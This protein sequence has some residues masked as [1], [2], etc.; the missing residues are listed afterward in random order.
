MLKPF[1]LF[2]AFLLFLSSAFALEVELGVRDF[3]T[4]E[5]MFFDYTLSEN[6][7]GYVTY[8]ASIF[9]PNGS[10]NLLEEETVFLNGSYS[11]VYYGVLVDEYFGP[12][13]CVASLWVPG[14]NVSVEKEFKVIAP[15]V[16]QCEVFACSDPTCREVGSFVVGDV[17]Y[18]GFSCDVDEVGTE[19]VLSGP[20]DVSE[21]SLPASVSLEKEGLYV[22]NATFYKDGYIPAKRS[23]YFSVGKEHARLTDLRI[24]VPDKACRGVRILLIV[25][26]IVPG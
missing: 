13:M 17:A 3:R 8:R 19:A 6:G 25:L 20:G 23:W 7:S 18:L 4:Y 15:P 22:V 12:Q 11:G 9:C 10:N 2:F 21:I 24:C 14:E 26:R 16:F 1:S 5:R